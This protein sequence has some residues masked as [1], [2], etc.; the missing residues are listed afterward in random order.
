M[1]NTSTLHVSQHPIIATKLSQLRDAKK[2]SKVVRE[3]TQ[4]L[5]VLLG[6]EASSGL[7]LSDG[8]SNVSTLKGIIPSISVMCVLLINAINMYYRLLVRLV[9]ISRCR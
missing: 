8:E 7:A 5:S 6:Y 2:D 9:A 1:T 4:D 3:L